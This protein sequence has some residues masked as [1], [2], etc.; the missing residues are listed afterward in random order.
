LRGE[1]VGH[2]E[3]LNG[4]YNLE[5]RQRDQDGSIKRKREERKRGF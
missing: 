5:E 3:K 2:S 4:G 1:G